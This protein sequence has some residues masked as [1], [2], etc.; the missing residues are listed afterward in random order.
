MRRILLSAV[1]TF[2]YFFLFSI[3]PAPAA[4]LYTTGYLQIDYPNPSRPGSVER[5]DSNTGASQG[6][7]AAGNGPNAP[8]FAPNGTLYVGYIG[9]STSTSQGYIERVDPITGQSLGVLV[10]G[11]SLIQPNQMTFGSDG[12]LYFSSSVSSV[13]KYNPTTGE[14]LAS[15]SISD[16]SGIAARGDTLYVSGVYSSILGIHEFSI[17]TGQ[18]EGVFSTQVND[19]YSHLA[20]AP[21]GTLFGTATFSNQVNVFATNGSLINQFSVNNPLGLTFG[22]DGDVYIVSN[23]SSNSFSQLI[24]RY[25]I[26]GTFLGTAVT[27]NPTLVYDDLAFGPSVSVPEP[28]FALATLLVGGIGGYIWKKKHS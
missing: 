19:L 20:F 26:D 25:S 5:Y 8:A 3:F 23:A 12:N 16:P 18:Y 17:A 10:G 27:L 1:S 6:M 9:Q 11:S 4:E 14:N 7:L 15:Y 13:E 21:D 24:N 22:N 28:T 2:L